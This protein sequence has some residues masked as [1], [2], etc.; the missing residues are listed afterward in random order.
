MSA[1][2]LTVPH[3]ARYALRNLTAPAA[4]LPRRHGESAELLRVD[5]LVADGRIA[6]IEPQGTLPADLGPDCAGSM[7]LPGMIDCHTHLDKGH[8]WP[9]QPNPDGTTDAAGIA[10]ARDREARWTAEDVRRRMDFALATA[11]AHGV[12]A[13]R[14][15]LD[16]LAP[17]AAISFPVLADARERWAGRI[18]LQASSIGPLDIFLTDEGRELA[19]IVASAGGNLG[20]ATMFRGVPNVPRPPEFDLAITNLFVLARERGLNVDLHVDETSDV[21]VQ[22]LIRIAQIASR[23]DFPGRIL[24]GHCCSLSLETDERITAT[25]DACYDA[26]I[27]IV[28]LPTVNLF[29][30]S[31]KP[32]VTPRWRGVAPVHEMRARGLRVAFGGDNARD[33]FY[34]YGDHD[35][36]DTFTQ[37]VKIAHLDYPL[38]DWV[39][40]VTETPAAI[41]GLNGI[42]VLHEGAAADV[43]VLRARSYSELLSRQQADRIV[44]RNGRPID[45]TP[46][47][48]RELDD[49]VGL[50]PAAARA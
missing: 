35:M 17:Q 23:V 37:A 20:C 6:A 11:Y 42:G 39:K 28:S 49:L 46:P 45:T 4:L 22:N 34:A 1:P 47:D 41:M 36:L 38:G 30:Q 14:S 44:I 33:P 32:G 27:D 15:H 25:L 31:R 24:C 3:G 21:N 8:I 48:Y 12:V 50:E 43:I 29:L 7:V 19:D 18:A 5:L 16:S 40:A 9:R 26:G 10:T 13:I 2:F